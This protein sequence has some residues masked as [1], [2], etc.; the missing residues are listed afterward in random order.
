[1]RL[2]WPRPLANIIFRFLISV[3]S[4]PFPP[5]SPHHFLPSRRYRKRGRFP[6]ER[7]QLQSAIVSTRPSGHIYRFSAEMCQ[8]LARQC[9]GGRRFSVLVR[10]SCHQPSCKSSFKKEISAVHGLFSPSCSFDREPTRT[11]RPAAASLF[12]EKR[13]F[14]TP[15]QVRKQP[16]RR[17]YLVAVLSARYVR[18]ESAWRLGKIR[19][20]CE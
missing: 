6:T 18:R 8:N 1:M 3:K 11:Q 10:G 20:D 12:V 16:S 15:R 4:L 13:V 7:R 19:S 17:G 5:T 9:G 14:L 2:L